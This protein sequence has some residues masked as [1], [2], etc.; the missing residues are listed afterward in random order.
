MSAQTL[1]VNEIPSCH[2]GLENLE[3][4]Y[5]YDLEDV[6][7][8]MPADI[9]STFYRVCDKVVCVAV[10]RIRAVVPFEKA[11]EVMGWQHGV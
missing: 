3:V 1:G 2:G 10:G 6:E 5:D 8:E 7:G 4:Q 9:K 11:V